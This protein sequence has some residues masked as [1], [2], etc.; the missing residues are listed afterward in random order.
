[1]GLRRMFWLPDVLILFETGFKFIPYLST[2]DTEGSC[3]RGR[4]G[5][6]EFIQLLPFSL[7]S[8]SCNSGRVP[9]VVSGGN[10]MRQ[11][12]GKNARG[13]FLPFCSF[14][15]KPEVFLYCLST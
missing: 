8:H 5:K 3:A 11:V 4:A 6:A 7:M 2:A 15:M 14:R 1:M 12:E 10:G 9:Q 13:F